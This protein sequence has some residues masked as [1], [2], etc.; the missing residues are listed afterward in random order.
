MTAST[1]RPRARL[2]AGLRSIDGLV[3]SPSM[4]D[5]DDAFWCNGKE[6]VHFDGPD[7]VDI[8]LTKAVIREHRP[9]LR[10]DPRVELRKGASDWAR[11]RVASAGDVAFAV[12]LAELCAAAHRAASGAM[13][14]PPPTGADL[15]RRRRFH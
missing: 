8:R 5:T 10:S 2:E 3:E 15:E 4:F 14:K 6:V 13:P 1:G 9:Q 7:V 12:E 11:V